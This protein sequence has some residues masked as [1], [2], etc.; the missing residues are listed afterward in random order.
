MYQEGLVYLVR[1]RGTDRAADAP[2]LSIA[3]SVA[4]DAIYRGT[5]L[6]RNCP[7]HWDPHVALGMGLPHDPLG[8]VLSYEQGAVQGLLETKDTRI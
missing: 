3:P 5:S 2:F 6:V 1:N 4:E 7:P 8:G